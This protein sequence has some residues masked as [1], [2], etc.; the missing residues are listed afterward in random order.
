M[1]FIWPTMMEENNNWILVEFLFMFHYF[2]LQTTLVDVSNEKHCDKMISSF[3]ILLC[4][5]L[6]PEM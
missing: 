2:S 6:Y 1:I 3:I 4:Q 5:F